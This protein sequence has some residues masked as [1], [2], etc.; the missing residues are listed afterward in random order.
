MKKQNKLLLI[1]IS[2]FLRTES[3]FSSVPRP[4]VDKNLFRVC[5]AFEPAALKIIDK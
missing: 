1:H 4:A 5:L 2:Q 3:G